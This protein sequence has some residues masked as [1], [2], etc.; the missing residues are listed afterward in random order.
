MIIKQESLTQSSANTKKRNLLTAN[1]A[2]PFRLLISTPAQDARVDDLRVSAYSGASYFKTADADALRRKSDPDEAI[3]LV[4]ANKQSVAATIRVCFAANRPNASKILQGPAEIKD[5]LFPTLT[6][7][8]GATN[9]EYRGQGLMTFLVNV[10]VAIA[11]RAQFESAIG[12]QA[13][14]TPHFGTMIASGWLSGDVR[15]DQLQCVKLGTA[16]MKLVYI[17]RDR[18][19]YSDDYMRERFGSIYK[20]LEAQNAIDYAAARFAKMKRPA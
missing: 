14:G 9:T 7:C 2:D 5:T 12:M 4:I 16:K 17:P 8:R 13:E 1:P 15:S 10:S 11:A 18:F 19:G 6:L 20:S 3:C